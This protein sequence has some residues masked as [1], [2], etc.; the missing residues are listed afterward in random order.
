MLNS[1]EKKTTVS[2]VKW[3]TLSSIITAVIQFAQILILSRFF[4]PLELGIVAIIQTI[5]G[6]T[7]IFLDVGISNAIVYKKDISEIQLSSVYWVNIFSGVFFT[8]LLFVLSSFLSGFY[9]SEELSIHIKVVCFSFFILS[10]SRLFKFLFLK[11]MKLKKLA[12]SE[13]LSYSI[14]LVLLVGLIYLEF[15]IICFVYAILA[16]ALVQSL[17]LIFYGRKVFTP[18][19]TYD[20]SSLK[21]LFQYGIFNLGQNLTVYFTSQ[22]DTIIIGKLLGLEILGVYNIAKNLAMKPLQLIAPVVSKVTFPLMSK[23]QDDISN[24]D[25]VYL[26]SIKHLFTITII[27]YI[28][29]IFIGEDLIFVLYGSQWQSSIIAFQL[30]CLMYCVV[31]IGNPIG[32]VILAS[33]KVNWGFYWNVAMLVVV[34][35][36]IIYSCK[37]GLTTLILNLIFYHLIAFVCSYFVITRRILNVNFMEISTIVLG[38][39]ALMLPSFIVLFFAKEFLPNPISRIIILPLMSFIIFVLAIYFFDKKYFYNLKN[40]IL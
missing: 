40:N 31:S 12:L 27:I 7:N 36:L 29:A 39:L 24:F 1:S 17:Y 32:S 19:L 3:S 8:A 23:F 35:L 16:R 11:E 26:L 37:F 10:S 9:N 13:V 5:V 30:L 14:S 18:K 21:S 6:F 34:T 22:L 28:T 4:T 25:K 38:R 15:G 2:G 33:G 20:H